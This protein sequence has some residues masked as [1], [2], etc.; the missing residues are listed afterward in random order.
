M[1]STPGELLRPHSEL[2]RYFGFDKFSQQHER[3]L[4]AEVARLG[5]ND[6]GHPFL[7]NAQ[8]GSHRDLL[9][10]DCNLE[11]TWQIRLVEFVRVANALVRDKFEVGTAERVGA[12]G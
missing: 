1:P 3:L 6:V 7:K 10:G 9:Q 2:I 12:S 5:G 8:V 4:P 11:F